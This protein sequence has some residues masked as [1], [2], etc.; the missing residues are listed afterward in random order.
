MAAASLHLKAFCN[1][2]WDASKARLQ[3]A[4]DGCSLLASESLVPEHVHEL[5]LESDNRPRPPC[6]GDPLSPQGLAVQ[7]QAGTDVPARPSHT[8]ELE[9]AVAQLRVLKR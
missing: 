5:V 9:E 3:Q 1:L 6:V 8:H 7:L 4:P 2:L